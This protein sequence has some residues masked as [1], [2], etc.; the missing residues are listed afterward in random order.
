MVWSMKVFFIW[1][2][3]ALVGHAETV[4]ELVNGDRISGEVVRVESGEVLLRSALLGEI[5]LS[6]DSIATGLDE[7]PP[8]PGKT[9]G[10]LAVCAD[11]V[12]GQTAHKPDSDPSLRE[13]LHIPTTLKGK[14]KAS[15]YR[16][17]QDHLEDY[18]EL[19]PSFG[20]ADMNKIH[21]LTWTLNYRYKR[22]NSDGEW[23]V[24]DNRFTAEQKY[25]YTLDKFIFA[26]SRTFW[27][28]DS[29]DD[30]E[31]RLVQ[32]AGIGLYV[33]NDD[34]LKF[35]VSPGVGYEYLDDG[36]AVTQSLVP[37]FEQSFAWKINPRF[38]YEQKFSFVGDDSEFQYTLSHELE[39]KLNGSFSF[40]LKHSLE[41]EKEEDA[42]GVADY[43][44]DERTTASIQLS[45]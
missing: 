18:L 25:R 4:L 32:S 20:W 40:M 45:F 12:H 31:P 3:C 2:A 10:G 26:Q 17:R 11:P 22:D 1:L 23:E 14:I 27:E 5:K 38:E 9:N 29:V 19:A 44:R 13:L 16:R 7:W 28:Q 6:R 35:D 43:S 24:E 41:N 42:Y 33:L 30:V 36:D 39:A 8:A 15:A 34:K 21:S 37:T